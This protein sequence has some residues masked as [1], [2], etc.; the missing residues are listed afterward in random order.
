MSDY[1]PNMD[2]RLPEEVL[3]M[4]I[5]LQRNFEEQRKTLENI[6]NDCRKTGEEDFNNYKTAGEE[7]LK[8]I[9]DIE[10][11]ARKNR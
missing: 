10:D 9:K 1:L 3:R 2:P 6:L 7:A 4:L 11:W 5:D 8:V